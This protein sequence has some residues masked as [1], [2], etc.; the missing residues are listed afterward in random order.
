[1]CS[2]SLEKSYQVLDDVL[3]D[4]GDDNNSRCPSQRIVLNFVEDAEVEL[5]APLHDIIV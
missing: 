3:H 4:P 5:A 2:P 1:L